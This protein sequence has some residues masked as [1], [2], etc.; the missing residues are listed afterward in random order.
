MN[1]K[2]QDL[3]KTLL[4]F[5]VKDVFKKDDLKLKELSAEDKEKLRKLYRDLEQQVNEFVN[6]T[7]TQSETVPDAVVEKAKKTRTTLRDKVRKKK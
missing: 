2:L 3:S 5:H 4:G 1:D 6:K 7:K